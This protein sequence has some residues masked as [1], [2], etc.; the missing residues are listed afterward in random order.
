M[1][2][3]TTESAALAYCRQGLDIDEIKALLAAITGKM[4][5]NDPVCI[6]LDKCAERL[7]IIAGMQEQAALWEAD[8]KACRRAGVGR[9]E[10][11]S[12]MLGVLRGSL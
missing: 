7:D 11:D 8:V 9:V 5:V 1:T 3:Q 2:M 4:G 12:R 6:A 10:I